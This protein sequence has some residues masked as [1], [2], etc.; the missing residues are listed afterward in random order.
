MFSQLQFNTNHWDLNQVVFNKD[1]VKFSQEQ[2]QLKQLL[3]QLR[4]QLC[5]LQFQPQVLV[6][7]TKA[8][9]LKLIDHNQVDLILDKYKTNN[10]FKINSQVLCKEK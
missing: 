10:Q 2:V 7:I 9:L 3:F 6:L 4:D 5:Q 8:H 1:Q